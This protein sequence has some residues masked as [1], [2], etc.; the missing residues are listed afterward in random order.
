MSALLLI[1]SLYIPWI[2]FLGVV[3][4]PASRRHPATCDSILGSGNARST[5][6]WESVWALPPLDPVD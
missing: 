6:A 2:V 3:S 5:S 4:V 1:A